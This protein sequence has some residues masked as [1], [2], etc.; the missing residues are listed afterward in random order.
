VRVPHRAVVAFLA[1]MAERPGLDA[2]ARLCAVT[3][4][5]F[6]IAV[7]ELW[8]PLAVGAEI[9]LASRDEATDGHALRALLEQHHVTHLQATP[10]TWRMLVASGWRGGPRFTA[11]CGG[12]ALPAEL[13]EA[14][15]ERTGALWN[16]YGP[17]ETTVWSTCA[18]IE[19][20]QG[21]VS[22]GTPIA[23]TQVWIVDDALRPVPIGVPGEIVIGGV[24][25]ALG[26]HQ[27]PGAH[28][29]ALRARH[30]RL[31]TDALPAPAI[32]VAGAPTARSRTSVAP[33]SR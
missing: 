27:R 12:E 19:P 21:D 7:L 2:D 23:G 25:V 17:T 9:V 29:R 16:M 6:D 5:S 33:T 24:G 3:T 18:R 1:A 4:L 22:I 26:Y 15:L 31:G 32:S 14:L 20:G 13:A 30:D 28:R 8:L 11:L 10:A